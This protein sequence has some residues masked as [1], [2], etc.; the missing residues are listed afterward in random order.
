MWEFQ[1]KMLKEELFLTDMHMYSIKI[2]QDIMN[3][4]AMHS[5]KE[6]QESSLHLTHI[7]LN[8]QFLDL[9]WDTLKPILILLF[10][11]KLNLEILLME[12]KLLLISSS[13]QA[14]QNGMLKMDL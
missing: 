10:F 11:G 6:L 13:V 9:N 5:K 14:K 8:L 4:S 3:L 7:F 2:N 1:G 12:H